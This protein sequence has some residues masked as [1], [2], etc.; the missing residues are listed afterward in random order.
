MR[1]PRRLANA[2]GR[3]VIAGDGGIGL[4][5]RVLL[6]DDDDPRLTIPEQI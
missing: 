5:E 6:L 1:R 2:E 4:G 3:W